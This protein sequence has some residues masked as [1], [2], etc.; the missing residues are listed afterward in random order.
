[1]T[2]IDSIAEYYPK[3][4]EILRITQLSARYHHNALF[5]GPPLDST[6]NLHRLGISDIRVRTS[7]IVILLHSSCRASLVSS[8]EWNTRRRKRCFRIFQIALIGFKLGL[9]IGYIRFLI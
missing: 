6:I 1:M 7:S 9:C 5:T 4:P 2:R 8:A 3:T